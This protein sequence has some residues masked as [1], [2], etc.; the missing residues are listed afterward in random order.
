MHLE[1]HFE[2]F[3]ALV[4]RLPPKPHTLNQK[5][6]DFFLW[7]LAAPFGRSFSSVTTLAAPF[8]RLGSKFLFVVSQARISIGLDA[9]K[10]KLPYFV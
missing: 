8:S 3:W 2:L 7:L 4:V 6:H 1:A 9:L 10:W 5:L